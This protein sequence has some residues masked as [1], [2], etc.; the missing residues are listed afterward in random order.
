MAMKLQRSV[1]RN[2]VNV[3]QRKMVGGMSEVKKKKKKKNQEII[4][5]S[6]SNTQTRT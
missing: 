3:P 2:Q 4:L 5:D 6:K 1:V